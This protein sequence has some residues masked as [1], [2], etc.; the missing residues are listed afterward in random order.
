M[1][2][3]GS[4]LTSLVSLEGEHSSVDEYFVVSLENVEVHFSLCLTVLL[5]FVDFCWNWI[6]CGC[7]YSFFPCE[8]L[9]CVAGPCPGRRFGLEI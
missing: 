9:P 7:G 1:V 4:V 5:T 6:G 2:I 8:Y 3:S